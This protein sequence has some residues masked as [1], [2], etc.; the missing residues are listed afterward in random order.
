MKIKHINRNTPSFGALVVRN[1]ELAN[2]IKDTKRLYNREYILN[3]AHQVAS[4]G[5]KNDTIE[6]TNQTFI[7]RHFGNKITKEPISYVL[8]NGRYAGYFEHDKIGAFFKNELPEKIKY[9][10]FS[11]QDTTKQLVT[12]K[13]IDEINATP[14]SLNQSNTKLKSSNSKFFNLVEKVTK[15]FKN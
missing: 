6:F 10:N 4:I 9:M 2:L 1:K 11:H 5:N 7:Y 12:E 13:L 8:Y 3:L 15:F 14:I